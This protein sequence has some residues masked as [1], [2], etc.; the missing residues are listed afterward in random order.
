[1]LQE[2]SEAVIRALRAGKG[3]MELLEEMEAAEQA[4]NASHQPQGV[5]AAAQQREQQAAAGGW[6]AACRQTWLGSIESR[7]TCML[8]LWVMGG[9]WDVFSAGGGNALAGG[10]LASQV[11]LVEPSVEW[12]GQYPLALQ[13][14][15]LLLLFNL[16]SA[17]CQA[18]AVG[19]ASVA[20]P[21][22]ELWISWQPAFCR[23]Q[24]SWQA[25]GLGRRQRQPRD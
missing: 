25:R 15:S 7:R 8:L 21:G 1:M 20:T 10:A 12:Q 16:A 6:E 11:Q 4:Y 18:A 3:G 13:P 9:R 24:L 2:A 14:C 17:S 5:A 19:T 22:S 23:I